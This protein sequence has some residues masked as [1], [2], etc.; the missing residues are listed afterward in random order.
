MQK[1]LKIFLNRMK[2]EN[3]HRLKLWQFVKKN[4]WFCF[5]KFNNYTYIYQFL[6]N[7]V[8]L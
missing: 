1:N 8:K 2:L 6:G 3:Q 7:E 4:I 5:Q